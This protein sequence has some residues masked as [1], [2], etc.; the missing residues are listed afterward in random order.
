MNKPAVALFGFNRPDC[1]RAVFEKI[2]CYR[3]EKLF[4]IADGPRAAVPTDQLRCESVRKI[5]RAVDW[6]CAVKE[7]FSAPNLG[8]DRRMASGIDWVFSQTETAI[9]L[10]DDCVPCP[11]F[12]HFCAEMLV[13][14]RDQPEVMHITGT[15]LQAGKIRGPGSY[16]F[17]R[18]IHGWGWASWRR[19]WNY[20][21]FA[22]S[23]W[24]QAKKDRW[25]ATSGLSRLEREYWNDIFD[26]TYAGKLNTWDYQ[27]FYACWRN[28][29]L[30]I[31]PNV[32]L[33][34]NIGSGPDATH[35]QG[36][37]AIPTGTLGEL[38]H[39]RDILADPAADQFTFDDHYGG[40]QMHFHRNPF[41][42]LHARLSQVKH[43]LLANLK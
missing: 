8:C 18:F 21:D 28:N 34:T 37:A 5:M 40:N 43:K 32:N 15:N 3:P 23:S 26:R 33:V 1:T 4:L 25:L 39:P 12:F 13:R 6:D 2:R 30:G 16:Y 9:F 17:S 35:T 7:N 41:R 31:I 24:P 19:A 11:D 38:L 29:G 20:F 36:I 27:W 14:Y 10:E 22:M 42:R